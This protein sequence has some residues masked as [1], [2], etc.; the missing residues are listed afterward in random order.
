MYID[1][2][3]R[4]NEMYCEKEDIVGDVF[5]SFIGDKK[6]DDDETLPSRGVDFD[7][8]SP[9]TKRG[10]ATDG[11]VILR[12][13]GKNISN[14]IKVKNNNNNNIGKK[15][16]IPKIET[17]IIKVPD[18][19]GNVGGLDVLTQ[20]M[21]MVRRRKNP[22]QYCIDLVASSSYVILILICII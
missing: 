15:E 8:V 1:V 16:L 22:M 21:N 5:S 11:A 14:I 13:G 2:R 12:K 18:V 9:E 17:G 4:L 3:L 10:K 7:G 20:V 6:L 19:S